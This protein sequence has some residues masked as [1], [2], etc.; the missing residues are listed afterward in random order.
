M[1]SGKCHGRSHS[2]HALSLSPFSPCTLNQTI[3]VWMGYHYVRKDRDVHIVQG[4]FYTLEKTVPLGL[5]NR[6]TDSIASSDIIICMMIT[7]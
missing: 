2:A 5:F 6:A 1:I 3:W 4:K 7:A